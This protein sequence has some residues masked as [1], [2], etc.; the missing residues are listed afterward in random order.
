MSDANDVII[1][2]YICLIECPDC[3]CTINELGES[4]EVKIDLIEES[5][6][7]GIEL[8]GVDEGHEVLYIFDDSFETKNMKS[9]G[10]RTF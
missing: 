3:W 10:D 9:G 2:L 6:I 4:C 8:R 5:Y 1:E 7:Q